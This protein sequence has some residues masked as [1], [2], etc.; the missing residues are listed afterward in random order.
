MKGFISFI[1]LKP[2]ATHVGQKLSRVCVVF[3]V[4][5]SQL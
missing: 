3:V 1:Q 2:I 5:T 4:L